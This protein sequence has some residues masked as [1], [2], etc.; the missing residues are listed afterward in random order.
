MTHRVLNCGIGA[1]HMYQILKRM[2]W[3]T[4]PILVAPNSGYPDTIRDRSVYQENEDYFSEKMAEISRL[5]VNI[6]GGCCGTTPE[7]IR[8]LAPLVQAPLEKSSGGE[9][10]C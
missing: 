5:G 7:Y 2:D 1:A 6:I 10:K 9:E 4:K 3:G 8:K